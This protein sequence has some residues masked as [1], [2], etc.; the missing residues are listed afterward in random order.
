MSIPQC[1]ILEIPDTLSQWYHKM[2]LT[3][4]FWKF[5]RKLHCGNV[6]NMPYYIS[7]I[8]FF[9]YKDVDSHSVTSSVGSDTISSVSQDGNRLSVATSGYSSD[10]SR[11]T[12][13]SFSGNT[14]TFPQH[15]K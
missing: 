14:L 1:I 5:Q 12:K 9:C 15:S 4:Y 13:L 10:P 7:W 11:A 3:E 2:I 6:V 8:S